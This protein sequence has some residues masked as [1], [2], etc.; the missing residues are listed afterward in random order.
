[1]VTM[2]WTRLTSGNFTHGR[3]WKCCASTLPWA[4]ESSLAAPSLP[5]PSSSTTSISPGA[6][7]SGTGPALPQNRIVADHRPPHFT[8]AVSRRCPSRAASRASTSRLVRSRAGPLPRQ[9]R[10]RRA[11]HLGLGRRVIAHPIV[12]QRSKASPT[13]CRPK[14]TRAGT[15][16]KS[17]A[18]KVRGPRINPILD[19]CGRLAHTEALWGN[20]VP[21]Q[22]VPLLY[23]PPTPGRSIQDQGVVCVGIRSQPN[24][25]FPGTLTT[26]T[27]HA[28][29]S[30]HCARTPSPTRIR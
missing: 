25:L 18:T 30:Y 10:A 9:V 19:C 15:W 3:V 16:R 11:Q 21:G 2:T 23:Y 26:F 7:T 13:L 17:R 29:H 20:A 6:H 4:D 22:I 14:S 24:L 27:A 28:A 12:V 5:W 1:M 8:F